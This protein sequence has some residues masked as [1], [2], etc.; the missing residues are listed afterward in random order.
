MMLGISAIF[1]FLLGAVGLAFHST[2]PAPGNI[3]PRIFVV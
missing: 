2:L 3:P 1:L